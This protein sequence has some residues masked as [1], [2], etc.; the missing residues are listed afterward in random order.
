MAKN[1]H[2]PSFVSSWILPGHSEKLGMMCN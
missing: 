2:G 1:F